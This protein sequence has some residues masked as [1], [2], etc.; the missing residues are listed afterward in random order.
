MASGTHRDGLRTS[1]LIATTLTE[2]PLAPPAPPPRCRLAAFTPW[3]PLITDLTTKEA[4]TE[5]AAH[6]S[7]LTAEARM[8]PPLTGSWPRM[9]TDGYMGQMETAYAATR[10]VIAGGHG[11]IRASI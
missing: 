8:R 11:Q 3:R 1:P 10:I 7:A 2:A 9:L 4:A 6:H 5:A